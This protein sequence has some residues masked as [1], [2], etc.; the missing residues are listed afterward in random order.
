LDHNIALG[1]LKV[2]S[3]TYRY[4]HKTYR[5]GF[6]RNKRRYIYAEDLDFLR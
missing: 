5:L 1:E 2:R 3:N 4:V 6:A